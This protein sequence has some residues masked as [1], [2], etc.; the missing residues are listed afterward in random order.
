LQMLDGNRQVSHEKAERELGY[1]A[2]P[3]AESVSDALTW[4]REHDYLGEERR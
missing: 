3:L 4:F 1:H 2:S